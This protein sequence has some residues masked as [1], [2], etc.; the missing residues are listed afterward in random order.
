MCA[1]QM[2]EPPQGEDNRSFSILPRLKSRI[3]PPQGIGG[4]VIPSIEKR[5]LQTG[6]IDSVDTSFEHFINLTINPDQIKSGE[7]ITD[8]P[9]LIHGI[10]GPDEILDSQAR[11]LVLYPRN[12][13]AGTP[14]KFWIPDFDISTGEFWMKGKIPLA[15]ELVQLQLA[16][17]KSSGVIDLTD[18]NAV[19]DSFYTSVY[20][21]NQDPQT[22][23]ILDSTSNNNDATYSG[24]PAGAILVNG[25]VGKAIEFIEDGINQNN[26]QVSDTPALRLTG[27][28]TIEIVFKITS[29]AGSPNFPMVLC[30]GSVNSSWL[31]FTK[32]F[33]PNEFAIRFRITERVIPSVLIHDVIGTAN[34]NDGESHYAAVTFDDDGNLKLYVD[35]ELDNTTKIPGITNIS[36]TQPLAIGG[37]FDTPNQGWDGPLDNIIIQDGIVRSPEYIKARFNSLMNPDTFMHFGKKFNSSDNGK[38]K[39]LSTD[40]LLKVL[41]T[42]EVLA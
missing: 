18:K 36:N 28:F 17:K 29:L 7:T 2:I 8:L 15:Q 27:T 30:K 31:M 9:I 19:Y 23:S 5:I 12:G 6:I 40:G 41:K 32:T 25:K 37:C 24:T 39:V 26:L 34:L 33:A 21:M 1:L 11:D 14:L 10:L 3:S 16:F 20:E 35:G 38:K 42:R 13:T 4:G 22:S